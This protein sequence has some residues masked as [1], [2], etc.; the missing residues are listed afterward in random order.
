MDNIQFVSLSKIK[1]E[2]FIDLMNNPLVGQYLP[3]LNGRFTV[4]DY[5]LFIKNKQRI[6]DE[7]GYG[8]Y[9][10]IIKDTF[11]GWGGLQPENED[12]DFALVLHPNFWGWGLKVFNRVKDQAFNQHGF[13]SITALLPPSR[14]N[15]KAITRLGFVEDQHENINGESFVKFRLSAP[16]GA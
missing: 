16:N 13:P 10:I 6:W 5:H 9:A 4:E 12:V 7:Y 15:I 3:L 11:A 2:Q 14:H 8:P 1:K